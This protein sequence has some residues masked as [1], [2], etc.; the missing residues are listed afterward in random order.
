MSGRIDAAIFLV[1]LLLGTVIFAGVYP[2]IESLTTLGEFAKAD[3]LPD[4]LHVSSFS[5]NVVMVLAA[6]GVFLL[7]SWMEKKSSGPVSS[8]TN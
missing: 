8:T 5:V 7:G 2:A 3:A 1:G 4:A 6:V